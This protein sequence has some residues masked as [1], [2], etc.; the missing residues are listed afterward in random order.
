[1]LAYIR[2]YGCFGCFYLTVEEPNT[3]EETVGSFVIRSVS[4]IE[5]LEIFLKISGCRECIRE[6]KGGTLFFPSSFYEDLILSI[7]M[8]EIEGWFCRNLDFVRERRDCIK[9]FHCINK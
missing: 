7:N 1:M 4:D 9:V 3:D 5:L 6:R 2:R 8:E